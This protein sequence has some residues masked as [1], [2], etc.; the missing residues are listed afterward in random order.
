MSVNNKNLFVNQNCPVCNSDLR[1]KLF[2][3]SHKKSNVLHMLNYGKK[4]PCTSINLCSQC[5]QHYMNPI[6]SSDAMDLYYTKSNSEFHHQRKEY[7][8]EQNK[9]TYSNYIKLIKEKV[10]GGKVLE[11]GCGN[12]FLL[13]MLKDHGYDCSGVE[14]SP[15]ASAF[16]REKFALNVETAYLD[17]STFYKDKFD[18]VILID[19]FEH[20]SDMQTFMKDITHVL[21]PGGYIFVGTGNID[22]FTARLAK[23]NWGYFT[24][25]EHISFFTPKSIQFLL[26]SFEF[27]GINIEKTSVEHKPLQNIFEFLK[28]CVKKVVNLFLVNKYYHGLSYDHMI[29]FA[30]YK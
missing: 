8:I 7:N 1:K 14:P 20:I 25:W 12:G 27:S 6:I 10:Q 29:V 11:V 24:S 15:M 17:K 3:I 18:L 2:E 5:T 28:N 13:K 19:V 23:S 4:E 16:A 26:K 30:K 9:K 21:K 22:S